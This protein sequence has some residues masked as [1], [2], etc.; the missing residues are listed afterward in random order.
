M[1][2][3]NVIGQ[4]PAKER[5]IQMVKEGRLPHALLFCGPEGV[6][7]MALAM[8]F[9]SYLL[10]N[11][12]GEDNGSIDTTNALAMLRKWEHPDLHFS[13]PTIKRSNMSSDHQPISNDF[14]QEWHEMI[15]QG[16]YFTMNQWMKQ[17]GATTQQAIITGAESDELSR[18]LA[19][20]SSQGGY[21]IAIIWRPERMNLTSAN[22]L[23]KLLEEPPHKTI[24]LMVCEEPE[25]LLETIISRTQRIDVKRIDDDA[26]EQALITQRGIDNDAAHRI[27]RIA[28]GSWLKALET[29]DTGNENR[30]FL[31]M[32]QMLMRLCYMRNVKDLKRWSEVVSA[33]GR[34][35]E[36]RMLTYFQ[37]QVREN[38]IFNFQRPELNYMTL[39][40]EGFARNFARFINEANVIEI[41][42]L[43]E[44][45]NR[46]IGQNANAK[47]VFYDIALKLIVL[48][49]KK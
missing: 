36:R 25:K 47:V 33:Y 37:Q 46:D 9:A 10:T 31:N 21:K 27:A 43:F 34:E 41:N 6:G 4:E 24:F 13:Y 22:K 39:E 29:L 5:L 49:L 45:A 26:I 44:K 38:F 28:N 15:M 40:E 7:K 23:L 14:T 11:P 16:T 1:D 18:I 17:M 20:K 42:E 30:E 48:L 3:S 32:F 35:K 12:D 19:L 8:A 2:F